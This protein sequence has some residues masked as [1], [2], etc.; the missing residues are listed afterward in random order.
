MK[1]QK[2]TQGEGEAKE[3]AYTVKGTHLQSKHSR[4]VG[5]GSGES[6]QPN[7]IQGVSKKTKKERTTTAVGQ[8]GRGTKS[9]AGN[10]KKTHVTGIDEITS[11]S[12][13]GW[14]KVVPA[15]KRERNSPV[16]PR[17]LKSL[18]TAEVPG[19]R[20]THEKTVSGGKRDPVGRSKDGST[21][22]AK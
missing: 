13:E 9:S 4:C 7:K 5:T 12:A 14:P 6:P 20:K 10:T 17:K 11:S 21:H 2:T 16:K 8:R 1:R 19:G 3:K 22:T 15:L 18:K